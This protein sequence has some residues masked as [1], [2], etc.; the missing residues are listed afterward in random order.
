MEL[1]F[2]HFLLSQFFTLHKKIWVQVS[3][4]T[5]LQ[6]QNW[7]KIVQHKQMVTTI[8]TF[9]ASTFPFDESVRKPDLLQFHTLEPSRSGFSANTYIRHNLWLK[10]LHENYLWL[11]YAGIELTNFIWFVKKTGCL[12]CQGPLQLW[13]F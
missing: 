13:K 4:H 5:F 11:S 3:H 10:A 8:L 6:D 7:W 1:Q 9:G 2:T 12:R